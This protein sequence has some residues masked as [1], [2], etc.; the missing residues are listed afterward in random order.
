MSSLIHYTEICIRTVTGR[1]IKAPLAVQ[2]V[3]LSD[4]QEDET[5]A[6]FSSHQVVSQSRPR[7]ISFL[8]STSAPAA[9]YNI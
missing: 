5:K 7:H 8:S 1:S 9:D 2:I 6:V 4:H 3:V